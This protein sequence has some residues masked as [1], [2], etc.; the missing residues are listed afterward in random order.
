MGL[1][2]EQD[3]AEDLTVVEI[4]LVQDSETAAVATEAVFATVAE[5]AVGGAAADVRE[6]DETT[7]EKVDGAVD[8]EREEADE[9]TDAAVDAVSAM[10]DEVFDE[11][12]I[13]TEKEQREHNYRLGK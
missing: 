7:D 1:V 2:A 8:E 12:G 5:T 6:A 11:Q 4:H 3:L 9:E 13:Q 10:P